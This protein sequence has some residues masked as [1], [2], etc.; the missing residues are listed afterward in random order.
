MISQQ[1]S[2]LRQ[3]G[4]E[5]ALHLVVAARSGD[6]DAL[7]QAQDLLTDLW[8]EFDKLIQQV[9]ELERLRYDSAEVLALCEEDEC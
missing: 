5:Y 8:P 6:R 3:R 7:R 2:S 1:L 4:H 9:A